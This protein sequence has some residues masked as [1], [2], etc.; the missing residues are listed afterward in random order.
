MLGHRGHV[1]RGRDHEA[2][3]AIDVG[4]E[5]GITVGIQLAVRR[6]Q[7]HL[8]TELG[9]VVLDEPLLVLSIQAGE[10]G[11]VEELADLVLGN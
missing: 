3:L 9:E 10:R 7:D 8:L 5:Q 4:V 11:V 1:S 6:Q 2:V